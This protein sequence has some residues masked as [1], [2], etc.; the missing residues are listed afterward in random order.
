MQRGGYIWTKGDTLST[1]QKKKTIL[2][3]AEFSG[4]FLPA[5]PPQRSISTALGIMQHTQEV[6]STRIV[7]PVI[8][9]QPGSRADEASPSTKTDRGQMRL[10][11]T[12]Q[13]EVYVGPST[14]AA[15]LV[16][17]RRHLGV[18]LAHELVLYV[19]VALHPS[20]V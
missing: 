12:G 7:P 1:Q 3:L 14:L 18:G 5:N 11:A 20:R 2:D 6:S 13:R 16:H 9:A 8:V 15:K 19:V 10:A 17:Q 4:T